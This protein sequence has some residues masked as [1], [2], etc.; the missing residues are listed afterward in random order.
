MI[1]VLDVNRSI[2][3][4]ILTNHREVMLWMGALLPTTLMCFL[5]SVFLPCWPPRFH[6]CNSVWET[7]IF[8][9]LFSVKIGAVSPGSWFPHTASINTQWKMEKL[10]PRESKKDA[11][12]C[13]RTI[14]PPPSNTTYF[15]FVVCCFHV[16]TSNWRAW[17]SKQREEDTDGCFLSFAQTDCVL[18]ICLQWSSE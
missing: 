12:V 10:N 14:T 18:H 3:Y 6:K 16:F 9:D 11:L 4:F 17:E 2:F 8:R 13:Q 5:C 15:G 1:A 7:N